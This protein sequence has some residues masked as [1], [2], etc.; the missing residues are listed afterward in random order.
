MISLLEYDSYY[1]RVIQLMKS[2]NRTPEQTDELIRLS[3][4]IAEYDNATPNS[5]PPATRAEVIAH[6]REDGYLSL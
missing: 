5:E 4:K 1:T 6:L 2:S 3:Q